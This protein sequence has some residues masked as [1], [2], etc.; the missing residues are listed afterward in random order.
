MN[1]GIN[2]ADTVKGVMRG[3]KQAQRQF[4]A[5]VDVNARIPERHPIREIK[6]LSDEVFRRL[7][8]R[9]EA[10]YSEM[11][12]PSIPP[13]RLLGARLLT[14][15]FSVP[16]ERA[17]CERLRYDLLFQWFLDLELDEEPFDAS[18]FSKNQQRLLEHQLADEFFGEV[19][20]LL[21][22][23]K[24]LSEEH[25]SVDGTLIE[26]WASLKSFRPKDEGDQGPKDSNGWG[27]FSGEKRSNQTHESKTDPEAKLLKKGAGKEAKLCFTGHAVMENRHGFCVSLEVTPSVGVTESEIALEQLKHLQAEGFRPSSVGADKG[28]H[29]GPFVAGCRAQSIRAHVARIQS[30][31]V[32]GLDGRTTRGKGYQL[33]QT[34]RKRTEQIFGW[35]KTVGGMRRS[36][37]R[38]AER[39]D[40]ACKWVVAALNLL[41]L[42]KLSVA[43]PNA[44]VRA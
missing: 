19:V 8:D 11:G 37:Y 1:S 30:R 6:G 18:T 9:L 24:L 25:F 41:R 36:R 21:R 4:L 20:G 33:S 5:L 29:N 28:Y 16:S 2:W 42:A 38:G 12:R 15:L 27:D 7:S 32:A 3:R 13:E 10:M 39:T 31:K 17:F 22:E 35:M 44:L 34:V 40:A 14:A 26:A 43:P 23:R